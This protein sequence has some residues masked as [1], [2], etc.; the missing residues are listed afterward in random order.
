MADAKQKKMKVETDI[1]D[2]EIHPPETSLISAAFRL[3]ELD[4]PRSCVCCNMYVVLSLR[5]SLPLCFLC[6]S[7][8]LSSDT[9][10]ALYISLKAHHTTHHV[11]LAISL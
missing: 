3:N 2:T 5:F 11:V 8:L 4:G 6:M 9:S 1:L 7:M 10:L